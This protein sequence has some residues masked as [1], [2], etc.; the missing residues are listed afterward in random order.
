MIKKI[1]CVVM[2]TLA[3][4]AAHALPMCNYSNG[5]TLL[6]G[7]T[8]SESYSNCR[9]EGSIHFPQCVCTQNKQQYLGCQQ[10]DT[11]NIYNWGLK[12]ITNP[13]V[14]APYSACDNS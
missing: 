7:Q 12:T 1:V 9:M 3:P 5:D 13:N 6:V 10:N 11:G 8:V 4:L 14:S 2:T